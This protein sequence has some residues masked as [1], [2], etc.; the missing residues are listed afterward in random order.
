MQTLGPEEAVRLIAVRSFFRVSSS[1]LST[2]AS[3]SEKKLGP[4]DHVT[5]VPSGDQ[6]ASS[7]P[8]VVRRKTWVLGASISSVGGFAAGLG[9]ID[10]VKL[11]AIDSQGASA[12]RMHP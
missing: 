8:M 3:G 11:S 2:S 5:F 6:R 1:F 4:T 9:S 12:L 7:A 10:Q